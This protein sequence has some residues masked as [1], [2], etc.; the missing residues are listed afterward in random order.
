MEMRVG[1]FVWTEVAADQWRRGDGMMVKHLRAK[2]LTI[3]DARRP[4]AIYTKSGII[5]TQGGNRRVAR[6]FETAQSAISA[7]DKEFPLSHLV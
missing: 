2:D 4:W 7:C 6:H 1:R 5:V 3:G